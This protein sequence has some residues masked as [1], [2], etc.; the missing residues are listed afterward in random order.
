MEKTIYHSF[1][2]RLWLVKQNEKFSWRTSLENPHTGQ[3]KF[4]DS[5][6]ELFGF[7][8]EIKE[9]LERNIDIS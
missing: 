8:Q 9:K 4:F 6:E 5:F 3:Q 1:L 2:L 7:F